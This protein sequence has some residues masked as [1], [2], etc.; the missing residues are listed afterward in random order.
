MDP[1]AS[2]SSSIPGVE[3]GTNDLYLIKKLKE[4]KLTI[5]KISWYC[6]KIR[7][8]E[9]EGATFGAGFKTVLSGPRDSLT[10]LPLFLVSKDNRID[11]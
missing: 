11:R 7:N 4:S 9:V 1:F 3:M 10:T 2:V 8:I 6:E 5:S